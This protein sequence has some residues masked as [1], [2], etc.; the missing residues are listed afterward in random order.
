MKLEH[1]VKFISGYDCIYFECKFNSKTCKPDEGG[2]HGRHGLDILFLVHGKKGSV[3]F[4]L[5][6]GWYPYYSK[7]S[8]IGTREVRHYDTINVFP[9]PTDL[10]Y[11]SYK[12]MYKDHSSMG[13]CDVLNGKE[14][15]YDGSGLNA[16][17]AFYILVNAGEE[18]LW[19]FLEEYYLCVFEKKK[20]PKVPEYPKRKRG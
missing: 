12:P 15:F 19:K 8:N 13:K 4:K 17:D 9:F 1:Q 20:Y 3:Q 5:S 18:K 11:H 7:Q 16:Q 10:G 14:C 6:T 2:S